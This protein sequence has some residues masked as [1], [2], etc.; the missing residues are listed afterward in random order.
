MKDKKHND[1]NENENKHKN[2][3]KNIWVST[4]ST[5]KKINITQQTSDSKNSQNSSEPKNNINN[6]YKVGI[7]NS[8]DSDISESDILF[9]YN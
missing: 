3:H 1:K 7:S 8:N 6:L 5:N 9:G 2:K 4:S